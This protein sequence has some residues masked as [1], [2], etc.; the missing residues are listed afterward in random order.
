MIMSHCKHCFSS[1]RV[2]GV[3]TQC[4]PKPEP[5][6]I[7]HPIIRWFIE[8]LA[9]EPEHTLSDEACRLIQLACADYAQP[10]APFEAFHTAWHSGKAA[11]YAASPEAT[12]QGRYVGTPPKGRWEGTVTCEKIIGLGPGEYGERF[13]LI[14]STRDGG[15]PDDDLATLVWFT[16][17]GGKFDPKEGEEYWVRATV[18]EHKVYNGVRQTVVQRMKDLNAKIEDDGSECNPKP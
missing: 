1:T 18:K 16:G 2:F 4:Q 3:C 6:P 7:A 17:E 8:T 15:G 14:F 10:I 9:E 11:E 5:S 12:A 13:L